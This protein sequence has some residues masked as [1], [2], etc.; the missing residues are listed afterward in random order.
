MIQTLSSEFNLTTEFTMI[1]GETYEDVNDTLFISLSHIFVIRNEL[2]NYL[3][4]G[5]EL[6][7]KIK[8]RTEDF[9]IVYAGA[10][11]LCI[12]KAEA[13]REEINRYLKPELKGAG[14]TLLLEKI[15]T[16]QNVFDNFY[17][18]IRNFRNLMLAH[19]FR[20]RKNNYESVHGKKKYNEFKVPHHFDELETY[21]E[22]IVQF[23][24]IIL[25]HFPKVRAKLID[26]NSNAQ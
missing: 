2:T 4:A 15:E 3:H 26:E 14:A 12:I 8:Q 10:L 22:K 17:P 7:R 19:P 9:L 1:T 25:G 13:I 5:Q 16:M 18:E 6:Q 21:L 20:D 24:D 11:G 23:V